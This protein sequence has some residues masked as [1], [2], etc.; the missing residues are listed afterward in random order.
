MIVVILNSR[1]ILGS[2]ASHFMAPLLKKAGPTR[3]LVLRDC[4]GL[5]ELTYMSA[6]LR[7][8]K[9]ETVTKKSDDGR[10]PRPALAAKIDA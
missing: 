9:L 8:P 6:P 4:I 7:N 1:T 10:C 3:L 2:Q 5:L